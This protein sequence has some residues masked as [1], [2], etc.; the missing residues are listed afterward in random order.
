MVMHYLGIDVGGTAI[1]AGLVDE[2]GKLLETGEAPTVIDDLDGFLDKLTELIRKFQTRVAIDAIGI[3]VP[4]LHSSRTSLIKTSPNIPCLNNINLGDMV[5]DQV[6]V[7]V[8]TENDANAG[9]YAEFVCGAGVG[10]QQM[11]YLTLGTGLG[12]GL[13][14]NGSLFTGASGYGGEFGHTVIDR[15]GRQCSCGNHGC[16]ETLVSATG[17]V[18]TAKEKL[19]DAPESVLHDIPGPL[20]SEMIYQA[21]TRGD[22]IAKEVFIETGWCLGIACA[23]L[24]N[25]LNL[26]MI[27]LGGGVMA[28]GDLLLRE[29]KTAAGYYAFTPSIL[30]CQI[31]QS[32]LWPQAGVIGAAMLARDR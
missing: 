30:D 5:A 15:K 19:K 13:I 20:T 1:K 12:S 26:E 22:R 29:A 7:R 3:G 11:A 24:I 27:V 21:A 25:L 9:A 10:L 16:L 23:T 4:G 18:V 14:L 28:S 17:I 6:H 32:K 2:T 8:I 31:V